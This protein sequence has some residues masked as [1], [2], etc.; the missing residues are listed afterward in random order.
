MVSFCEKYY[1]WKLSL[2]THA[3]FTVICMH[4][5]F[6]FVK[7]IKSWSTTSTRSSTHDPVGHTNRHNNK[8]INL[9]ITLPCS[10]PVQN[11]NCLSWH[12]ARESNGSAMR[13]Q[14]DTT[15]TSPCFIM[16]SWSIMINCLAKVLWTGQT[17]NCLLSSPVLSSPVLSDNSRQQG[18][19]NWPVHLSVIWKL[20][21][22]VHPGA[23]FFTD[24]PPFYLGGVQNYYKAN[25]SFSCS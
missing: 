9:V 6:S 22:V 7:E 19:N 14:T 25:R 2:H 8:L 20:A 1:K 5:G 13:K 23:N 21:L 15:K 17:K 10:K 24:P 11:Y 16:C 12:L 3:T 18:S 4:G